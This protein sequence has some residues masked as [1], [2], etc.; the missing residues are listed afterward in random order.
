MTIFC[1][2][3][4][5]WPWRRPLFRV[6]FRLSSL[7]F[8]SFDYSQRVNTFAVRVP[9]TTAAWL[10]QFY[11]ISTLS[12]SRLFASLPQVQTQ[13]S[14]FISTMTNQQH[15]SSTM[16]VDIRLCGNIP[17]KDMHL[18]ERSLCG[19][20]SR[21]LSAECLAEMK[22]SQQCENV[23]QNKSNTNNSLPLA[24][25]MEAPSWA[26]PARGETRLEVCSSSRSLLLGVLIRS[27]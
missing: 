3:S 16:S 11:R 27:V 7:S 9:P 12:S 24:S 4:R 2:L 25:K 15:D 10:R 20:T 13:S 18:F 22:A 1:N 23:L 6:L 14:H 8:A 26:V 5:V 21:A 17:R 19:I